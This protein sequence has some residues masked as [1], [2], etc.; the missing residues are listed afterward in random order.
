MIYIYEYRES[1]DTDT[2]A[3]ATEGQRRLENE[4]PPAAGDINGQQG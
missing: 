3:A 1:V 4:D 2:I